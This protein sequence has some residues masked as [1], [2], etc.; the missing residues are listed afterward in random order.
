MKQLI[1]F[2]RDFIFNQAATA[3]AKKLAKN[4]LIIN[5][6]APVANVWIG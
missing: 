6:P 4:R 2:S 1:R 5:V 3:W